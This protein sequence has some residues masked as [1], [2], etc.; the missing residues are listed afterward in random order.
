[1]KRYLFPI[2]ALVVWCPTWSKNLGRSLL[3]NHHVKKSEWVGNETHKLAIDWQIDKKC[4][5][6]VNHSQRVQIISEES[7]VFSKQSFPEFLII[8]WI[9]DSFRG[10]LLSMTTRIRVKDCSD[11]NTSYHN[12]QS[13]IQKFIRSKMDCETPWDG[14]DSNTTQRNCSST[15]DLKKYF[16]LRLDIYRGKYKKEL[17]ECLIPNCFE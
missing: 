1:M 5:S 13:C 14:N 17:D 12:L 7:S 8:Y 4:N 3:L 9:F 6:K 16:D 2:D 11:R 10:I 15:E